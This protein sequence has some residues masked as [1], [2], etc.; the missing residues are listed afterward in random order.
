MCVT[1]KKRYKNELSIHEDCASK[2]MAKKLWTL[3]FN[4]DLPIR[5]MARTIIYETVM[6][7]IISHI[8]IRCEL[9]DI[10]IFRQ[11]SNNLQDSNFLMPQSLGV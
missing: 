9:K 1:E 10:Y 7:L 2:K 11:C 8:F 6:P 4:F 5:E 3:F